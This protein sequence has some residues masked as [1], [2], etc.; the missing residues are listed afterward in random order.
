MMIE[1]RFSL[2]DGLKTRADVAW[3]RFEEYYKPF[4]LKRLSVVISNADDADDAY[5]ETMKLLIE[6]MPA[7]QRQQAGSFRNF[8]YEICRYKHLEW[9]AKVQRE[10]GEDVVAEVLEQVPDNR[11]EVAQHW[12]MEHRQFAM[13]LVLS[14]ARRRLSDWEVLVWCE[15][16]EEELSRK[17]IAAKHSISPAELYR[18]QNRVAAVIREIQDEWG[19]LLDLE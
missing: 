15:L 9:I 1:T 2:L 12:E 14:E 16:K 6:K 11:I 19:D 4:L 17:E 3:L 18:I 10:R 5:Q 13:N 7:F 8:L